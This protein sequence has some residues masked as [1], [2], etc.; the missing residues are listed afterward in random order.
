MPVLTAAQQAVGRKAP[1]SALRTQNKSPNAG[2]PPPTVAPG[3]SGSIRGQP[4]L[5]LPQ[6]PGF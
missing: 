3:A 6:V 1:P 2:P 4:V 5:A